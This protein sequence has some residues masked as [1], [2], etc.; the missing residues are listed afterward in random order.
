MQPRDWLLDA[1]QA[2][3][4]FYCVGFLDAV[5]DQITLQNVVYPEADST[6]CLPHKFSS[7]QLRLLFLKY[8]I[9][10]PENLHLEPII[11]LNSA[12]FDSYGKCRKDK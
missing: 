11:V 8:S 7:E 5:V 9:E 1:Q 6:P 2:S 12:L 3:D 10:N 4:A